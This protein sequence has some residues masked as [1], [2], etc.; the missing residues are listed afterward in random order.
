MRDKCTC[1]Y[2]VFYFHILCQNIKMVETKLGN[3]NLGLS[4]IIKDKSRFF[5]FF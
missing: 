5:F 3:S 4:I 2:Q 1:V